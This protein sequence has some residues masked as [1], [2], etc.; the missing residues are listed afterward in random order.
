VKRAFTLIELLVVIAIIAILAAILFPVF[1]QAKVAAKKTT[2]ISNVKQVSTAM[3]L[4]MGDN[5]DYYPRARPCAMNSS[6]NPKFQAP[7][8]NDGVNEGCG[9]GGFH[10]Y[11]DVYQWQKYLMPYSKNLQLFEIPLR[12]KDAPSWDN[13]GELRGNIALN[14]GL[15]GIKNTTLAGVT[16]SFGDIVP[17]TGG[18]QSGL[19]NVAEAALF[20]DNV[21]KTNTAFIPIIDQVQSGQTSTSTLTGYPVSYREFWAFRLTKMTTA[22][23]AA[24]P[25]PNK[26]VDTGFVPAGGITVGRADG[27]AKFLSV[28]AFLA[29]TP[30]MS[31]LLTG[32]TANANTCVVPNISQGYGYTGTINTNIN[33]PMWGYGQ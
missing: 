11:M 1:A 17:F 14:L 6:L 5:D 12:Q 28:G 13:S 16:T 30:P 29:K 31:Q 26:E 19:P 10:N 7:S 25:Q 24:N 9:T 4:Y 20:V 3:F 22:E 15:T 18:N 21:P 32:G 2:T 33:Y 27:S 23:C 8:Y